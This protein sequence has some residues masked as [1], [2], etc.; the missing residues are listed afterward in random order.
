MKDVLE[1]IYVQSISSHVSDHL[2]CFV[3]SFSG[4]SLNF[5]PSNAQTLDICQQLISRTD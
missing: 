3:W 2:E 1:I 5:T 4:I